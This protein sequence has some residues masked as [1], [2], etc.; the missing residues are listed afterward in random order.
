MRTRRSVLAAIGLGTA[1]LAGCLADETD[2]GA[3]DERGADDGNGDDGDESTDAVAS[4]PAPRDDPDVLVAVD[5]DLD[6]VRSAVGPLTEFSEP[7]SDSVAAFDDAVDGVAAEDVERVAGS[8]AQS[9]RD[10]RAETQEMA[11]VVRGSIDP[12][13]VLDWIDAELD[14][15]DGPAATGSYRGLDWAGY[16]DDDGTV[17]RGADDRTMLVRHVADGASPTSVAERSIDA[18]VGDETPLRSIDDDL[19]DLADS[20]A[21][22]PNRIVG[23]IDPSAFDAADGSGPD[24]PLAS[25]TA[26]GLGTTPRSPDAVACSGTVRFTDPDAADADALRLLVREGVQGPLVDP[27]DA[28]PADELAFEADGRDVHVTGTVTDETLTD[29]G[30][31]VAA[32]P[33]VLYVG[34]FSASDRGSSSPGSPG[35][36]PS[37]QVAWEFDR[38]DDGRVEITHHGGDSVEAVTV[39]YVADGDQRTEQWTDDDGIVAGASFVTDAPADEGSTLRLRWRAPDGD[40]EAILGSYEIP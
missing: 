22:D 11:A 26:V 21:D 10:G 9:E 23:S 34:G 7:L 29:L 39:E 27:G 20:I 18:A 38:R 25:T 33:P 28:H 32:F 14:R 30:R 31:A 4:L 3:A 6:A 8:L 16:E 15:D 40:G 17:V 1:A 36:P 5:A 2:P 35:S 37:P 12:A 13:P 24:E 19:T